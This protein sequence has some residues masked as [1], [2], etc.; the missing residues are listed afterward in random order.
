MLIKFNSGHD[1]EAKSSYKMVKVQVSTPLRI[2]ESEEIAPLFPL[3]KAEFTIPPPFTVGVNGLVMTVATQSLQFG[4]VFANTLLYFLLSFV[5]SLAIIVVVVATL[6]VVV[7]TLVVVVFYFWFS[8]KKGRFVVSRKYD[9]IIRNFKNL[10]YQNILTF[11]VRLNIQITS[12]HL[13][14]CQFSGSAANPPQLSLCQFWSNVTGQQ[15]F[16]KIKSPTPSYKQ[17]NTHTIF[18]HA[19]NETVWGHYADINLAETIKPKK[20]IHSTRNNAI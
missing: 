1:Q 2:P 14:N 19:S 15:N 9:V 6:V 3:R 7:A 12:L 16:L 17:T 4:A 20:H 11:T 10:K 18:I 13:Q 5:V 8:S